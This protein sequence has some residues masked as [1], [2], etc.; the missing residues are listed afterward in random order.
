M[1]E[2][3][4]NEIK[5]AVAARQIDKLEC[6]FYKPLSCNCFLGGMGGGGPPSSPSAE[7]GES[8]GGSIPLLRV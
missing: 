8:L 6:S 2:I 1:Y 3:D 7:R 5:E 4:K